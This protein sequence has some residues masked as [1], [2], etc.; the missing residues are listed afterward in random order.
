M[1]APTISTAPDAP[2]RSMTSSAF[3]AAAEAFVD[4]MAGSPAEFNALAAYLETLEGGTLSALLNAIS[5]AGSSAN[6]L[7]YYTGSNAVALAD[8]TAAGRALL[9]D[10]DAAAQRATLSAAAASQTAEQ[11][12]GFIAAPSDKS[13]KLVVKMA[14][15]GTITETTT[16]SASGTCTATFKINTT[17]LGG[18]ANSVSSSE[19]SQSHSS[20]NAF[21]AGDDIVLTVSS[22][23][24]CAD[25]SFSIK[26]SRTL[27]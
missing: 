8:L 15:A 23:S 16:I 7:A 26:Y 18:T 12:S 13:Y 1:P 20:S 21:A 3:I 19:Q 4:W 27:S 10:A 9:D 24:S 14:H 17:A 22:N 5:A 2:L 25:L 6:K 11:I